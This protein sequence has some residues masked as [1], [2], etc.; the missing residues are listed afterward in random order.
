MKSVDTFTPARSAGVAVAGMKG[1]QRLWMAGPGSPPPLDA[2]SAT[3]SNWE[4]S[5]FWNCTEP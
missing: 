3:S 4:M 1:E 2:A 5:V